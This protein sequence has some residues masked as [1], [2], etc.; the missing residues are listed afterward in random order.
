MKM[1]ATCSIQKFRWKEKMK[2][3]SKYWG[4]GLSTQD[5][6]CRSNI[7]GSRP[8]RRWRLC[9]RYH[10]SRP[11]FKQTYATVMP[12]Y[13]RRTVM[14]SITA[15]VQARQETVKQGKDADTCYNESE[16]HPRSAEVW[17]AL[18]GISQFYLPPTHLSANGMKMPLPSQ[19]A[20]VL[21]LPTP[22]GWKAEST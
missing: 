8:L 19:P 5:D 2:Q 10:A 6:P 13:R 18:S 20:L 17:H 16:V 4:G 1:T 12:M 14:Q 11:T 21:I 22:E 15:K 3:L 7:G 9:C